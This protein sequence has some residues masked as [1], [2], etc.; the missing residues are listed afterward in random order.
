MKPDTRNIP[1]S[2]IPQDLVNGSMDAL[3]SFSGV[4]GV[5]SMM[6]TVFLSLAQMIGRIVAGVGNRMIYKMAWKGEIIRSRMY[7]SSAQKNK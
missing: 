4:R 5:P 1:C 2:P 7:A 3:I 6:A